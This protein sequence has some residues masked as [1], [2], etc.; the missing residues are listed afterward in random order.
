MCG[1]AGMQRKISHNVHGANVIDGQRGK[2]D[3]VL[4]LFE[5]ISEHSRS[6]IEEVVCV[7]DSFSEAGSTRSELNKGV[8]VPVR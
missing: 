2:Q 3:R 1:T 5:R 7:N 4:S 8:L 6:E